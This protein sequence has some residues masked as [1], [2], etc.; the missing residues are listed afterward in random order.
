MKKKLNAAKALRIRISEKGDLL[1][2]VSQSSGEFVMGLELLRLLQ[3]LPQRGDDNKLLAGDLKKSFETLIKHLPDADE[4]ASLVHDLHE[5]GVVVSN[6]AIATGGIQDGFGDAWTQ[7]AMLAD[8]ERTKAYL[9]T[10]EKHVNRDSV[11]LD[12][13]AGTGVFSAFA[14]LKGAKHVYAIEEAGIASVI[15]DILRKMGIRAEGRFTLLRANSADASFPRDVNLV[16]SELLG[17]DAFAEGMMATLADVAS[18]ID[19]KKT[20]FI[21]GSVEIFAEA[22]DVRSGAAYKRISAIS[23]KRSA[24]SNDFYERFLNAAKSSL[25]FSTLSFSSFLTKQDFRSASA[26]VSLGRVKL[27][28]PSESSFLGGK[29]VLKIT[30]SARSPVVMMW[31]RLTLT[32]GITLSSRPGEKDHADHWSPV[33]VPL[34]VPLVEG[35]LLSLEYGADADTTQIE[36]AVRCNGKAI[37]RR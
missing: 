14:L 37:G 35:S 3:L 15:P 10:L 11:V 22:V 2:A 31:F 6:D 20:K 18:R 23:E 29:T 1:A 5:A 36:M 7:W 26:P 21:P 30:Q 25:D 4:V 34:L 13:G 33:L 12:V 28:P 27:G 32:E 24:D 19:N 9:A 16:V 17:N 8:S